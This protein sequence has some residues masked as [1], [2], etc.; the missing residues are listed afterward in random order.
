MP[1]LP[2]PGKCQRCADRHL[3][4]D[5][6]V[7][8]CTR[9]QESKVECMYR[10]PVVKRWFTAEDSIALTAGETPVRSGAVSRYSSDQSIRST[11]RSTSTPTELS[12]TSCLTCRDC[13]L[14][15]KNREYHWKYKCLRNAKTETNNKQRRE[16][17]RKYRKNATS[18]SECKTQLGDVF[19]R[20]KV[21]CENTEVD[22]GK[23]NP[24]IDHIE[25]DAR[26]AQP[27]GPQVCD[28]H[29]N[30][31]TVLDNVS[32]DEISSECDAE[33][34]IAESDASD[35]LDSDE[36][37]EAEDLSPSPATSLS[38]PQPLVKLSATSASETPDS[39]PSQ[40]LKP[41][42]RRPRGNRASCQDCG[43]KNGHCR[44][45]YNYVCPKN[46]DASR[47]YARKIHR[48]EAKKSRRRKSQ[49]ESGIDQTNSKVPVLKVPKRKKVPQN[50]TTPVIKGPV[51]WD[52]L[53]QLRGPAYVDHELPLTS[54][55]LKLLTLYKSHKSKTIC[56]SSVVDMMSYWATGEVGAKPS[57]IWSFLGE[58]L[59]ANPDSFEVKEIVSI[60]SQYLKQQD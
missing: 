60:Y 40:A 32:E 56:W 19:K 36:E 26:Q 44:Y 11:S 6:V 7:P 3:R 41:G 28:Q 24:S 16:Y 12:V 30:P 25:S 17:Y 39:A 23:S 46:P 9:C 47:N 14:V 49:K 15:I 54:N 37:F 52:S 18:K 31:Q 8:S 33:A 57:V 27:D 42:S 29:S 43:A 45:H 35:S 50:I 55:P 1:M 10:T 51:S 48:G 4:C 21:S 2:G 22:I 58:I 13:G 34:G 38:L 53:L 5:K 20:E 59:R